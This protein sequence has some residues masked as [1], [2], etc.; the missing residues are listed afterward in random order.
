LLWLFWRWGLINYLPRLASKL[1][2]PDLTL[3]SSWDY[4]HEPPAQLQDIFEEKEVNIII[5]ALYACI[6]DGMHLD[7]MHK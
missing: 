1:D 7:E 3:S 6:I 4:R 5:L 2:P